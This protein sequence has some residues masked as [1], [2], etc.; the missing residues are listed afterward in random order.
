MSL[1]EVLQSRGP[2]GGGTL[3]QLRDLAINT[4]TK[5][6]TEHRVSESKK[7]G[8][9]LLNGWACIV[10]AAQ[11]RDAVRRH[12]FRND[13]LYSRAEIVGHPICEVILL[14]TL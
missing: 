3:R 10:Q 5:E 6:C 7:E 4:I 2:V 1:R 14:G 8:I 9:C 12:A 11:L 13:C